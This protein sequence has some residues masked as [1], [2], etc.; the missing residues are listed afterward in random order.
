MTIK[1]LSIALIILALFTAEGCG[2]S[3]T[4]PIRVTGDRE[5]SVRQGAEIKLELEANPT[6]GYT[7]RVKEAEEKGVLEMD[8][9]PEYAPA[10]DRIGSGGIQTYTFK[11][12]RRGRE[13]IILEYVRPWEKGKEPARRYTVLVTVR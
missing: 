4:A 9:D 10:S 6:T 1:K 12:L 7:W 2:K 5:V 11:T 13:N 3:D 8:G